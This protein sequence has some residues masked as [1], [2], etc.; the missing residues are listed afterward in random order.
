MYAALQWNNY[1]L[2]IHQVLYLSPLRTSLL[3]TDLPCRLAL[4]PAGC[5]IKIKKGLEPQYLEIMDKN[6]AK[7]EKFY[8]RSGNSST[9]IPL[10]E[11]NNYINSR[12]PKVN[13]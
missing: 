6:G 12:F 3:Q 1:P 13:I 11:L 2:T 8:V 4:R 5:Q 7:A 9:E 10:H